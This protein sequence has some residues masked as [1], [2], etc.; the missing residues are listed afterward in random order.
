MRLAQLN[1]AP[2][3]IVVGGEER[4][5]QTMGRQLPYMLTPSSFMIA[6]CSCCISIFLGSF[7]FKFA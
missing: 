3:D 6:T 1:R 7:I 5:F 4:Q 2:Q